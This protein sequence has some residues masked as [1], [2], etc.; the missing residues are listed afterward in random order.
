MRKAVLLSIILLI[1]VAGCGGR[2]DGGIG[3]IQESC[4]T[5]NDHGSCQGTF[6]TVRG[7]NTHYFKKIKMDEEETVYLEMQASL[8]RGE[9]IIT[10]INYDGFPVD[11]QVTTG[12]PA[13]FEL[14]V[15]GDGSGLL[16]IQFNVDQGKV[17][18]GVEFSLSY[19]RNY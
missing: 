18:E 16:P 14:W 9:M 13:D 1:F 15:L 11:Y 17:V 6:K 10:V 12:T 19:Q 8:S 3:G 7:D 2:S 4:I 5:T